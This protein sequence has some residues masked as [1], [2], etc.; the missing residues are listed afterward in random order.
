MGKNRLTGG[1]N[2]KYDHIENFALVFENFWQ[3]QIFEIM[4]QY[5]LDENGFAL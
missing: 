2:Q 4:G 5:G 3:N 1:A